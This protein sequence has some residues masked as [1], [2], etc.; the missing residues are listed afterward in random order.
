MEKI[1]LVVNSVDRRMAIGVDQIEQAMIPLSA[2]IPLDRPV[3]LTAVNH[4][5]PFVM[6]DPGRPV[7][8]GIR[9]LA[10][11]VRGTLREKQEEEEEG[12]RSTVATG[13]GRL[14]LGHVFG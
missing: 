8:Q 9:Q 2:Q 4:G 6:R 12:E 11:C 1:A 5:V 3:V 13:A 10:E 7:S 14:R